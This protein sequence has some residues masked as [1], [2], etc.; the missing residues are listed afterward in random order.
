MAKRSWSYA[1]E[2]SAVPVGHGREMIETIRHG[3]KDDGFEAP[4]SKLCRWFGIPRRTVYY[5]PVRS[6][7]K[8]NPAFAEPIKAMTGEH[9]SFGS[10]TVAW[11]FGFNKSTVQ[12]SSSSSADWSEN[13]QLVFDRV[14]RS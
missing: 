5:A 11:L 2:K 10:R 13:A 8:V 3:L 7:P 14:L 12:R 4:V 6:A 1:R 9:P